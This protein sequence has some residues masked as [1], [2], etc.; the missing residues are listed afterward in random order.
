[1]TLALLGT[2]GLKY[3]VLHPVLGQGWRGKITAIKSG[4]GWKEP[5]PGAEELGGNW[6]SVRKESGISRGRKSGQPG[7]IVEEHGPG[8]PGA[9]G[10]SCFCL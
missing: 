7:E 1:M 3:V 6:M 4:V 2:D 5:S 8:D 10:S 9:L